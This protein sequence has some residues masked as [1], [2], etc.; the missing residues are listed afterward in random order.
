LLKPIGH[1]SYEN[2]MRYALYYTQPLDTISILLP[3]DL[4][5]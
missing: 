4:M 5:E 1:I 2:M 3:I